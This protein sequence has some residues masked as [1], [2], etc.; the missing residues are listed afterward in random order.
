METTNKQPKFKWTEEATAALNA[1][2]TH[3]DIASV[4]EQLGTSA[5]SVAAKMRSLE[6]EVPAKP[7]Q[8]KTFTEVESQM[9][10]D[11]V[12]ANSGKMTYGDVAEKFQSGK[13]TAKQIQGKVLALE[14]TSH[15]A[16]TEKPASVKTYSDEAEAKFISMANA[17]SSIED[18]ATALE[19]SINSA[20]GK[21]LSLVRAEQ[22]KSIPVTANKKEVG[23]ADVLAGIDVA[24]STVA[25][26]AEAT[27]KT[28][29]GIKTMLTR[30]NIACKDYTPKVKEVVEAAA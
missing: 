11:Y 2:A 25:E 30:R 16:K 9:L 5:R 28:E 1:I 22:I 24:G 10:N 13:F 20:R 29:R 3:E 12:I 26:I 15:I 7:V 14:L 6:M 19:V 27:G 18:I 17:G 23:K 21:A 4:A 8:A